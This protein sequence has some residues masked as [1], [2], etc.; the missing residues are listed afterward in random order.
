M[1]LAGPALLD[2]LLLAAAVCLGVAVHAWLGA[3][4]T[5][6][7][8][9]LVLLLI[10]WAFGALRNRDADDETGRSDGRRRRDE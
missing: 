1:R 5:W 8:A 9:G 4:A 2:A 7:Y 10:W 3:A 6:A